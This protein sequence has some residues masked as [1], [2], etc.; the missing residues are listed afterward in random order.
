MK[1]LI[2]GGAGY[3]G[4]ELVRRLLKDNHEVTVIDKGLYGFASLENLPVH[5]I[6]RDVKDIGALNDIDVVIHLAS[7]VGDAACDLNPNET[8]EI[9]IEATRNLARLCK[10]YNVKMLYAS[11]CSVYGE[12]VG[13][14]SFEDDKTVVPI[15][16]YGKT[17]LISEKAIKDSGCNY[18][19]L[20]LGTLFG[21]SHRMRFDLA[22]N[23]FIAKALS[24]EKITIFGGD[25][26]R[27]FLH[28]KD[29]AEA[30]AQAINWE[31]NEVYNT[32]LGN[33][34][35]LEIARKISSILDCSYE[36]SKDIKDKRNY[37][38]NINKI[39][40]TKW[41]P[42][43]TIRDAIIEIETAYNFGLWKDYTQS[44]FSNYKSLFKDKE[45]MEKIYTRGPISQRR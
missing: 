40:E 15:S 5:I 24:G 26:W 37:K 23:L 11:T 8:V 12:N 35:I 19:I 41:K 21:L 39:L 20:R 7:I 45:L 43:R 36:I 27:P 38:V 44:K 3:L 6:K 18:I 2:T 28:V 32:A 13:R 25:Q 1:I 9:N 31:K 22:I 42:R 33:Y 10:K 34:T 29:A 17:K 30:F 16:L 4:S 14:F